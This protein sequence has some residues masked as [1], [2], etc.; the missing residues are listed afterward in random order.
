MKSIWYIYQFQIVTQL[1]FIIL[2]I[3]YVPLKSHFKRD[4]YLLHLPSLYIFTI[5]EIYSARLNATVHNTTDIR[6]HHR[7]V[8]VISALAF[9]PDEEGGANRCA[10]VCVALAGGLPRD[11]GTDNGILFQFD[12]NW[13]R[14][15]L[16]GR[17]WPHRFSFGLYT[18]TSM[19]IFFAALSRLACWVTRDAISSFIDDYKRTKNDSVIPAQS[20][21]NTWKKIS[22]SYK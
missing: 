15:V 2:C 12:S 11:C 8:D 4:L 13:C 16:L 9:I 6:K 1:T 10:Q 5:E 20:M 17:L 22:H 21:I 18:C 19:Y 7:F 14:L 3:Y